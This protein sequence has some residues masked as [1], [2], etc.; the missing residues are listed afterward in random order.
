MFTL[1]VYINAFDITLKASVIIVKQGLSFPIPNS[2]FRIDKSSL[3][4][5]NF[6]VSDCFQ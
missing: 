3:T 1:N 4:N 5:V 6:Q 2:P